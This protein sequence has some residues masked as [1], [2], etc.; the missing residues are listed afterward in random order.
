MAASASKRLGQ[1]ASHLLVSPNEAAGSDEAA[2][3]TM[4][5]APQPDMVLPELQTKDVT[6]QVSNR[7]VHVTDEDVE[8]LFGVG[9]EL[10]FLKG[11]AGL[12]KDLA[13]MAGY[14]AE[15]TVDVVNPLNGKVLPGCRILGPPR[16]AT[17]VR[18]HSPFP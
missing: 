14:A 3:T 10:K 13:M 12:P 6:V 18:V 5:L 2:A 16:V 17:Q 4:L 11:L 8:R 1:V 15:E 7:H 9:Y